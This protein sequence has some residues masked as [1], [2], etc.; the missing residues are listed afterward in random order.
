VSPTDGTVRLPDGTLAGSILS[1]DRAVRNLTD[2]ADV[3]LPAAV[4]AVTATPAALLGLADRGVI[5]PGAVGDLVLLTPAGDL[6]ATVIAGRLVYD[7]R[8]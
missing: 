8:R 1:L 4:D 5:A 2:F 7:A 3:D 6:V